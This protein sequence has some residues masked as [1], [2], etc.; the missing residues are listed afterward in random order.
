MMAV[1]QQKIRV[2]NVDRCFGT[3]KIEQTSVRGDFSNT[4]GDLI[5]SL[6]LSLDRAQDWKNVPWNFHKFMKTTMART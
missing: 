4:T 6:S 5:L 2:R 3:T 1:D